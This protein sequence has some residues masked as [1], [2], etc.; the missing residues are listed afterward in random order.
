MA[1]NSASVSITSSAVIPRSTF[2]AKHS[3]VYS[4][5]IESHFKVLPLAVKSNTKSQHQT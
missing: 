2:N 5:T 4:S 1:N 3:R